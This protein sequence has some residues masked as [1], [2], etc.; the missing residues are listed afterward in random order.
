MDPCAYLPKWPRY[1][2]DYVFV[3]CFQP[4]NCS[5]WSVLMFNRPK[6]SKRKI[7]FYNSTIA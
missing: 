2:P 5:I 6:I 3:F 4:V 1:A 7:D